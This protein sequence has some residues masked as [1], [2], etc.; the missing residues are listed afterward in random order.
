MLV[1]WI[2]L[3]TR[4]HISDRLKVELVRR[5]QDPETIYFADA[6]SFSQ[7]EGLSAE[8]LA[9]LAD[10]QLTEAER[11]LRDCQRENL[12]ILPDSRIYP[13]RRWYFIIKEGCLILTA[14]P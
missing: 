10:K 12:G 2:W 1:H 8:G 13:T 9:V 6:D 5:F 3:S 14:R 11:I 7:V 4:P